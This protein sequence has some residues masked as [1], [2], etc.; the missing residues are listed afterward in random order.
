MFNT[1]TV[2]E[3]PASS[4]TSP[5]CSFFPG[6]DHPVLLRSMKNSTG[7]LFRCTSS[8]KTTEPP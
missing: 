6:R 4:S 2:L 8:L 3:R 1:Y 7:K 5:Q